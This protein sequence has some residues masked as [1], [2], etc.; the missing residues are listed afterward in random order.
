VR[1][2]SS[3]ELG[4]NA[5]LRGPT[6]IR[7]ALANRGSCRGV[8]KG[9]RRAGHVLGKLVWDIEDVGAVL[10]NIVLW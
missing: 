4:I 6:R 3:M 8:S 7:D 5:R 9:R 10:G 1:R 2:D